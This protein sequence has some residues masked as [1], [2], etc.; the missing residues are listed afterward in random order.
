MASLA[1]F[2]SEGWRRRRCLYDFRIVK[3]AGTRCF[4]GAEGDGTPRRGTVVIF[5]RGSRP[6]QQNGSFEEQEKPK[7]G[8]PFVLTD[9]RLA[10]KWEYPK[11]HR[12]EEVGDAG[13]GG[14]KRQRQ[15]LLLCRV[16]LNG[17][18]TLAEAGLKGS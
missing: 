7:R 1:G 15:A 3:T 17:S 8:K 16:P 5:A 12:P 14:L 2:G 13:R 6:W 4:P 10:V 18:P 11:G 9:G